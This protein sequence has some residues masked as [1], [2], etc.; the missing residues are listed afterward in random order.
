MAAESDSRRKAFVG[1][2]AHAILQQRHG[3][4]HSTG[5]R[6]KEALTLAEEILPGLL[7]KRIVP[8]RKA[9]DAGKSLREANSMVPIFPPTFV[10]MIAL[11]ESSAHLSSSFARIGRQNQESL[12]KI[13]A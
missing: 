3:N 13:M 9:V 10:K 11:A 5:V 4:H 6:L 12:K 7:R 1:N 2:C 8:I